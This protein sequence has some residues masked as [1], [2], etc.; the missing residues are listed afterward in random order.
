MC[1][2]TAQTLCWVPGDAEPSA[3][4]LRPHVEACKDCVLDKDLL[5]HPCCS[6]QRLKDGCGTCGRLG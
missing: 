6:S 3:G 1:K 2:I 5:R 4:T